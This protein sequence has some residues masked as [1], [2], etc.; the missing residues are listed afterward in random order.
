MS[1]IH[2]ISQPVS[3][4]KAYTPTLAPTGEGRMGE[5]VVAQGTGATARAGHVKTTWERFTSRFKH[6]ASKFVDAFKGKSSTQDRQNTR[7]NAR[8]EVLGLRVKNLVSDLA[9][10][11][12]TGA[13]NANT[14]ATIRNDVKL[15]HEDAPWTTRE[16]LL[17]SRMDVELS[18]LS[19]EELAH[20]H[21]SLRTADTSGLTAKDKADLQT[22]QRAVVRQQL[23]R[24]PEMGELIGAIN[25]GDP[26]DISGTDTLVRKSKEMVTQGK[27]ALQ[28]LGLPHEGN[29]EDVVGGAIR[30]RLQRDGLT[31]P[32][33]GG[34][35]RNILNVEHLLKLEKGGARKGEI[36]THHPELRILSRAVREEFIKT[37]ATGFTD[38]NLKTR[39]KVLGAGAAH[40]VT[41]GSYEVG[42]EKV[43]K[44]HKH[45]DEE[46]IH[47]S[48]GRFGAPRAIG[49]DQSNP[50]LLERA[51]VTSEFDKS[52]G[53][54]VS[55]GTDFSQHRGEIG[56]VMDLAKGSTAANTVAVPPG[57]G[58]VQRD[59]AK[60][61][62]L[63]CLT[64]Q[65]DRHNS[66]YMIE[67][68]P[69]GQVLGVKA[70]DSDFCL[71]PEPDD[72]LKLVG[73]ERCHLPGLPPVIDTDMRDSIRRMDDGEI[74][75]L[76]GDM[77]DDATVQAAKDRLAALKE[78]VNTLERDG[79]IISPGDWGKPETTIKLEAQKD[80]KP[81]NYWARDHHVFERPFDLGFD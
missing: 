19:G 22:M 64:G 9:K 15:L 55:V 35:N 21:D 46:L 79:N 36:S 13:E 74:D 73:D 41:K 4:T 70:I 60:L 59:L 72:A 38:D 58:V 8:H 18:G 76:M 56:I 30:L 26:S 42:G 27:T 16:K 47:P 65:G 25:R 63:D 68:G 7:F 3:L 33:L 53:F 6:G 44:V 2:Q 80:G 20:V 12:K 66:N 62:L 50:R 67:K 11:T 54:N 75:R 40:Q 31:G 14:L 39:M 43:G 57:D 24:S 23:S 37:K 34:M 77:F 69:G 81:T 61:Q 10:G 29:N 51:V 49:L 48:G 45:D 78:H 28:G 52:L 1:G 17:S 32:Q 5:R 71:G